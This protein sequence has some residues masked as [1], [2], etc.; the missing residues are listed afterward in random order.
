MARMIFVNLPVR[1]VQR[2]RRFF[3][4][5]GFAIN[6]Q[7]SNEI[8]VSI[9][10]EENIFAMLLNH[11]HFQSFTPRPI[12]DATQSTEVITAISAESREATDAMMAAALAAGGAE[13]RPAQDHGSMYIRA[14]T[15]PDGHIWEVAWM[16]ESP[17]DMAS[18][19]AA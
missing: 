15:D 18:A 2:S 16:G 5:L 6:E 7:F 4:A 13:P 3:T 8:A 14:F 1:D 12:A 19:A 10:I 11:E 17:A 9:I